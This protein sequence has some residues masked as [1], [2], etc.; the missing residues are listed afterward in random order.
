M[1]KEGTL[2]TQR[3]VPQ[4]AMQWTSVLQHR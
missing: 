3:L 1:L 2:F 4:H